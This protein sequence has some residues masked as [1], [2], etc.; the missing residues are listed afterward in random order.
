MKK[1]MAIGT[2]GGQNKETNTFL[3]LIE[4]LFMTQLGELIYECLNFHF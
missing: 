3:I 4:N 2:I 1:W